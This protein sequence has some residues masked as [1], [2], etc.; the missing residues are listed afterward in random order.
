MERVGI[1]SA[2]PKKTGSHRWSRLQS[3]LLDGWSTKDEF[4][5]SLEIQN[6]CKDRGILQCSMLTVFL[7][8]AKNQKQHWDSTA[9]I[10]TS[11]CEGRK[12]DFVA[13]QRQLLPQKPQAACLNKELDRKQMT[14]QTAA[15]NNC[16]LWFSLN[17]SVTTINSAG[18]DKPGQSRVRS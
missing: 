3:K 7:N 18:S 6:E 12:M 14:V 10:R 16:V 13:H 11:C 5:G 9:F 8:I 17:F 15:L 1:L 2:K 4:D